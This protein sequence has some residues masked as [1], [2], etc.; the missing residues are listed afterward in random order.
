MT[1]AA[2]GQPTTIAFIL[3]SDHGGSTLLD[4]L[5]GSH[6]QVIS[7]GEFAGNEKNLEKSCACGA[8]R[9][10]A[11]PF[12]TRV[13]SYLRH[14]RLDLSQI[15][16]SEADEKHFVNLHRHL[17]TAMKEVAGADTVLD[18]SKDRR[19]L[20]LLLRHPEHFRVRLIVLVR[21]PL[22]TVSSHKRNGRNIFW[23]A[24]KLNRRH[25]YMLFHARG[26]AMVVR[27]E[28][29]LADLESGLPQ[30]MTALGLQYEESQRNPENAE[31][32]NLGGNRMRKRG[33]SNISID[34]SWKARMNILEK[35]IVFILTLPARAFATLAEQVASARI[36]PPQSS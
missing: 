35:A 17:F 28:R 15:E 14:A 26:A 3:S 11:C 25:L 6:T 29:L 18:S 31:F 20:R 30:V 22:R 10:D 24:L 8:Q 1:E 34:D 4:I 16:A 2:T 33:I 13:Q 32:H 36:K 27:Y 23:R 12:W 9:V 19:R 21:E 5:I 7:G